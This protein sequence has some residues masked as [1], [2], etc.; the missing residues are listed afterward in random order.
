MA[1]PANELHPHFTV[2]VR[3]PFPRGDFVD[4]PPV[5]WN[6]LKDRALWDVLSRPSK[7]RDIDCEAEQF[8]VTLPFLLQQAAW[9]YDRQLSQVRAQ[10]RKVG[11][12]QPATPSPASLSV[13][14]SGVIASHA[15]KHGGSGGSRVPSRLSIR[16]RD[17]PSPRPDGST[18]STPLRSNVSNIPSTLPTDDAQPF[19]NHNRVQ[20]PTQTRDVTGRTQAASKRNSRAILD[21]SPSLVTSQILDQE[22]SEPAS[23]SSSDS[24]DDDDDPR[25]RVPPF[26]RFGRFSIYKPGLNTEDEEDDDSPAF[27]PLGDSDKARSQGSVRD[28]HATL[29]QEPERPGPSRF[30]TVE[31]VSSLKQVSAPEASDTSSSSSGLATGS[32]PNEPAR[33][34]RQPGPLSPRRAAELARL[35]PR[36]RATREGSDGTPSMGSSFSDLDDTSLTQSAL[37]EALLSNMQHGGVASR[38]SSI[39]QALRSRYL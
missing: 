26:K 8:N 34:A 33:V 20:P 5:E 23:S 35:S 28:T 13:S 14:G 36:R 17:V 6:A 22:S 3:V 37:E 10:V 1:P 32:A 25:R 38:M 15:V 4:P 9:L 21:P 29:R 31:H 19:R 7:G 18:P 2:L 30:R 24:D 11:N 16:Q 12:Q 39:S 27:L